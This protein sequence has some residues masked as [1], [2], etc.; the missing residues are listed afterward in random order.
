MEPLPLL[1]P[2]VL[3]DPLTLLDACPCPLEE[4]APPDPST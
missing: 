4:E 1:D 2:L 3:L